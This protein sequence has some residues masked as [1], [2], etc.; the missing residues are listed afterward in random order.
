MLYTDNQAQALRL[1]NYPKRTNDTMSNEEPL[2]GT[3]NLTIQDLN[4]KIDAIYR[5]RV[6]QEEYSRQV[7]D[8]GE[9]NL[10]TETEAHTLGYICDNHEVT[11]THLAETF[12]APREL[13]PNF[14]QGWKKKDSL[15][16]CRETEIKNGS[17]LNQLKRDCEPM[18]F[19][20]PMNRVKTLEMLEALLKDS[21]IE[22]IESFYKITA[23]RTIFL[24]K[25]RQNNSN[26][27]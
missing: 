10:M 23:L 11:V 12:S 13:F 6:L 7:H 25:Q 4:H 8:Y 15:P 2:S 20:V 3:L 1:K 24:E 18:N 26:S 9:G 27:L 22:E 16:A 5:H 19:T 14:W 21:T 17:I